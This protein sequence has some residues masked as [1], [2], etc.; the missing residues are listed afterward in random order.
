MWF[1]VC[2]TAY[3]RGNDN[4]AVG[5]GLKND[6]DPGSAWLEIE[7]VSQMNER[8]LVVTSNHDKMLVGVKSGPATCRSRYVEMLRERVGKEWTHYTAAVSM[9]VV[10]RTKCDYATTMW[11]WRTLN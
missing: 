9:N 6:C 8:C 3:E 11:T 7:N 2:S 1:R 5:R 10:G 4:P